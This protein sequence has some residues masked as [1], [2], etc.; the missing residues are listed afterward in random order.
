MSSKGFTH[1][2][3]RDLAWLVEGH[4]IECDFDLA[5]FLLADVNQRL[6]AL[7]LDSSLLDQAL[8]E[9]KSHFM[10]SYFE[11]LFS[12]AIEHLST[13]TIR[14]EHVQIQ[15]QGKTLGEVDMLVETP[16]GHLHQFEIA[17]KFYLER[18]DLAPHNWIGPN[19]ND[20]LLIKVTRARE[21]QLTVLQT[22]DGA[23]TLAPLFE[24]LG[25]KSRVQASLL[26]FGRLYSALTDAASVQAW[27]LNNKRGAWLRVRDLKCLSAVFSH[28]VFLEKPHWMA[29][30]SQ[31]VA[32]EFCATAL[33][34]AIGEWFL[35]D[36][37]PKHVCFFTSANPDAPAR[38]VFIVP[39]T[40]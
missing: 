21:H 6:K 9:C 8:A 32:T 7:D 2:I 25:K 38:H 35:Q 20:S 36:D 3:V 15:R 16:Q 5:P 10:G 34:N 11:T 19:K 33:I 14:L 26:M 17:I 31:N 28:V 13:L 37:R 29:A 40:W 30:P 12:F 1:P 39:D 24:T 23:A 22:E 18:P 4:Y 27:L